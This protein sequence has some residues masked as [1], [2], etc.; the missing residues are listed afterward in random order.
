[1]VNADGPA[2]KRQ[3]CALHCITPQATRE[4]TITKAQASELI[5]QA[6]R[7]EDISGQL[8]A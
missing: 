3:L 4:S 2:T 5:D 7:G 8:P 6:K 1:M